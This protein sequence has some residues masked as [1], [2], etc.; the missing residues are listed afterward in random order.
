MLFLVKLKKNKILCSIHLRQGINS[1][2]TRKTHR[3]APPRYLSL[4]R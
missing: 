1:L 4:I 2:P 3:D